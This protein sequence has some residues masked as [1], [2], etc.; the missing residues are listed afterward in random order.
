MR[1]KALSSS[2][3]G[4]GYIL[5]ARDGEVLLIEAGVRLSEVKKALDFDLS[6]ITACIVSHSHNDHARYLPAF[7][8]AGIPCLGNQG[9]QNAFFSQ[10]QEPFG[11]TVL[12][13]NY[14]KQIGSF[15]IKPFPLE[16]DVEN[17]GYLIHHHETGLVC[18]ITDTAYCHYK[19]K[20]LNNILI[21]ANYS[22][23]IYDQ[24][25]MDRTANI[26]VRNRVLTSHM[27]FETTKEFLKANDLT[28]VNNI[29]LLHLSM[30]NSDQARFKR[31]V[32]ELTGKRVAIAEP[33]LDIELNITGIS[34][35]RKNVT[36][37]SLRLH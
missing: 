4:N 28:K 17:Y 25:L 19:F 36:T 14:T 15:L 23:E 31:E 29:V 22:D 21:E 35:E 5:Q 18:F 26:Y 16:H 33:G 3:A 6:R 7:L 10:D 27:E 2:S 30:D 20:G 12:K 8:L 37:S 34:H 24:R 11:F 13:P 32:T 9:T 1:F